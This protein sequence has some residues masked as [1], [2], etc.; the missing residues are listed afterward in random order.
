MTGF[1]KL[2]VEEWIEVIHSPQ[3]DKNSIELRYYKEIDITMN[4]P[5]VAYL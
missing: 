4:K 3:N 5:G 2:G 1:F